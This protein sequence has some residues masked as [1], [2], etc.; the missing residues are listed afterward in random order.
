MLC[1]FLS[2]FLY[3]Q[4]QIEVDHIALKDFKKT[5]LGAFLNFS[6]PVSDADYATAEAGLLYF[7]N[8][9]TEDLG[10]IPMLAGYR[11]T[12]NRSGTGLY[13]EPNAGYV[14]GSSTIG[15]YNELG[16]QQSDGDKW[17]Y[18]KVSGPSAGIN[19]G[20]LFKYSGHI[21]FNVALRYEHSFGNASTNL[22]GF[23]ISHAFTF[24]RR[25]D[26]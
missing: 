11:Y 25:D 12:I 3:S 26:Y 19:V 20:Y 21:Q 18:E 5:S 24:G 16:Q 17:A 9:Y 14:Y 1:I 13:V 8:K 15:V 7:V 4:A 6:I 10:M 22:L 2:G 23:R